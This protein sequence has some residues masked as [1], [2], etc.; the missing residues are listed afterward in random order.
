LQ[1]VVTKLYMWASEL[2]RTANRL[3]TKWLFFFF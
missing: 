1:L 3:I 2:I